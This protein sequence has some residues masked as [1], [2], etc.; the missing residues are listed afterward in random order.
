MTLRRA[1]TLATTLLALSLVMSC[2]VTAGDSQNVC[3]QD[4]PAPCGAIAHCVLADDQYLQGTFPG[5]QTF[6]INTEE[7]EMVVFS[8]EFTNRISAGTTLTLTSAEPDCCEQSTYMSSG[9]IFQ[10]AGP[11]GI[12]S[13]PI[14]MT[15]AGDHLVQFNSDSYCS[16]Q[17]SY[18][19]TSPGM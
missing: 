14:T 9:D 19:A 18:Q 11:S 5:S 16:Y 10:L 13:F 12:L 2:G 15:Q 17:L 3:T 4:I 8:F 6:V 1:A 7:P